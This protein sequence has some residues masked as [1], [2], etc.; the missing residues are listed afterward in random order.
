MK[1]ITERDIEVLK[2][3]VSTA[4]DWQRVG[5]NDRWMMPLDLGGTNGS[6][7]SY[8]LHKLAARGLI[9]M[10]KYGGKREKGSCR[11]MANLVGRYW[12]RDH[13]D[14]YQRR[15]ARDKFV[16]AREQARDD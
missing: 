12:L 7:H 14:F 16:A 8:T 3:V 6:H 1:P 9:D 10:K 11:Y 15:A 13:T 2:D 5:I 4:D